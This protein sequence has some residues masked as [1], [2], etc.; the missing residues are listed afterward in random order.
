LNESLK[1]QVSH[2]RVI[3]NLLLVVAFMFGFGFAMVPLY[4]VICQITGIGGKVPLTVAQASSGHID[5]SRAVR[6]EFLT[7]VNEYMPVEFHAEQTKLDIHPGQQYKLLFYA[8]NKKDVAMV[9]QAIPNVAPGIAAAH[10][11]KL[12]CFCFNQQVFQAGETKHM[13]VI[14]Y[15]DDDLPV[16]VQTITLSYTFFDVTDKSTA[17]SGMARQR[18]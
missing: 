5:T 18:G 16:S 10:L 7:N 13:P 14:F 2:R 3:I 12:E 9:G 6:M 1:A 8:R 15:V 4:N 11:H 17:L